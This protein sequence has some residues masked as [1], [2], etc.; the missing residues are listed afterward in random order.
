MKHGLEID[1]V[2]W[3]IIELLQ[4]DGRTST[5]HLSRKLRMSPPSVADRIKRL[6]EAGVIAGYRAE[7]N[8]QALGLYITAFVRLCLRAPNY[9]EFIRVL[10]ETPEVRECCQI[11]E[12][13]IFQV[14]IITRDIDHL[15]DLM[16]KLTAFGDT[17]T[18]IVL[19]YPVKSKIVDRSLRRQE[20]AARA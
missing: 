10:S 4:R 15:R 8:V 9:D 2:D 6:E 16:V 7:V 11:S 18:S 17:V 5:A 12:A 13:N 1:T 19:A 3:E 14:K 20:V